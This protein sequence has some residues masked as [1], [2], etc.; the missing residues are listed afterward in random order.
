V[1]SASGF[2][3]ANNSQLAQFAANVDFYRQRKR[4]P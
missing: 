4:E 2:A 3:H 1:T